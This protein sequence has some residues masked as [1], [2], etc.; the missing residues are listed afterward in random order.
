VDAFYYD[1]SNDQV[2]IG[3]PNGAVT[4]TEFINIPKA[5]SDGVEIE[6]YWRPVRHLDLSL[7]YGFDHTA[8]TTGCSLVG[9]VPTGACYVDALDPMGTA[10][11]AHTVATVGGD[12]VQAVKGSALPQAPEN[13]VAFNATYTFNFDPGNLIFSASYIWKDKSYA[14]IF[15]RTYYEAPSWDQVDLRATWS[16]DHDRYEVIFF[17]RNLFNTLGYDAAAAGYIAENPVGN[18]GAGITQ[19]PAFDLTPPRTFGAEVHYK[20]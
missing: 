13:K 15:T 10:A 14:S 2:P 5:V 6:A 18:P 11:G 1:Y 7:T 19:V 12:A 3:V 17:V 4:S 9:G 16:G 8:I 20:F